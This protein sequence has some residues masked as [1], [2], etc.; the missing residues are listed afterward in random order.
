M[1]LRIAVTS[2]ILFAAS[3]TVA[4]VLKGVVVEN[5]VGGPPA[6]GV[7]ITSTGA[8]PTRTSADGR[9]ALDFPRMRP[10]DTVRLAVGKAGYIVVND[11]QLEQTLPSNPD[12]RPLLILICR[13]ASREEMARRY[14]R[15]RSLE[16]IEANYQK[17]LNELQ[18]ANAEANSRLQQERGQA[19]SAAGKAAEEPVITR[20]GQTSEVY[21]QAMRL[22]LDG[23]IEMALKVLDEEQLRRRRRSARPPSPGC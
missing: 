18:S 4:A 10:G 22:F 20:P 12:A 13:P 6:L 16:A 8:N 15:G 7:E 1:L 17:R 19:I 11:I 5:E 9:F 21:G 14:Y 3:P 23:Q 2:L